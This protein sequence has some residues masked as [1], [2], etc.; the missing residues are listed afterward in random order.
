MIQEVKAIHS[1]QDFISLP[2]KIIRIS[3]EEVTH[4]LVSEMRLIFH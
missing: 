1:K 3:E 4:L 2:I